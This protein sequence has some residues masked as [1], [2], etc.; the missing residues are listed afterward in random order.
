M[1]RKWLSLSLDSAM[2]AAAVVLG[3]GVAPV[4]LSI[5]EWLGVAFVIALLVHLLLQWPWIASATGQLR[6]PRTPKVRINYTLNSLLFV[7][8]TFALASGFVISRAVLP[9][10]GMGPSGNFVWTKV[11]KLFSALVIVIIGLHLG[12]NWHWIKAFVIGLPAKLR[13]RFSRTG[14]SLTPG[15]EQ[16]R[17]ARKFGPGIA[18]IAQR[19]TAILIAAGVV[20]IVLYGLVRLSGPAPMV[21]RPDANSVIATGRIQPVRD[22][23]NSSYYPFEALGK[24]ALVIVISAAAARFVL[25]LRI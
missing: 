17:A 3:A 12:M 23:R 13:S 16:V 11:H 7:S 10:L 6:A 25:R 20:V 22:S 8:M 5:H 15:S 1:N 19:L 4:P 2:L 14:G 9:T 21:K 18:M 24:Q